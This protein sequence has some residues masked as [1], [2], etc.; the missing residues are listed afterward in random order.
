MRYSIFA[1]I[2]AVGCDSR[3]TSEEYCTR[4]QTCNLLIPGKSVEECVQDIDTLMNQLPATQRDEVE[5]DV[6]MCLDHPACGSFAVCIQNLPGGS[7]SGSGA[8]AAK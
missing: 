8:A 2:L 7:G 6:Q 1:L 5:F 4:L 3:S